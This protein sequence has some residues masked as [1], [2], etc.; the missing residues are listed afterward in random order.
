MNLTQAE[1]ELLSRYIHDLCGLDIKPDKQYLIEQ[2]LEPLVV[3]ANCSCFKEYYDLAIKGA[4]PRAKESIVNVMTTNETSFFRDTH[5]FDAFRTSILPQLGAMVENRKRRSIQRRGA[6]VRIWSAG[7]STGQEPYSLAML[8]QEYVQNQAP[9]G[10]ELKDFEILATD[11]ST[12]VLGQALSGEYT[13]FEVRRGLSDTQL[14]K[15]F[16]KT[17]DTWHIKGELQEIIEFRRV[18]LLDSFSLLGGFD[19][20]FCRNVLIYLDLPTKT[21]I[22]DQF[23]SMLSEPG[24][25]ILGA[26]ENI[27]GVTQR[28]QSV[29][30][31]PSLIYQKVP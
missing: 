8:I 7:A 13:E 5:P 17:K 14:Q 19:L 22:F 28:F 31:G 15:Y 25:L 3:E 26:S 2:R 18:N 1:F 20:V 9:K 27:I 23:Y 24:F 10:T 29:S 4:I 6:K 30:V 11:I 21:K 16:E 12:K